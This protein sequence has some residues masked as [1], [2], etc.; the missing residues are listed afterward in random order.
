MN[1]KLILKG[2]KVI[3]LFLLFILQA[4]APNTLEKA[5]PDVNEVKLGEK[6]TIILPENHDEGILWKFNNDY[7]KSITDNLGAVWH[8]NEKGVY[9]RFQSLSAGTDTLMFTQFKTDAITKA[10]DTVKSV[11][12]I[13]KV[14]N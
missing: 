2:E 9:F 1:Y 5:A 8:G 14:T 12:Y 6:F 11:V 10:R 7:N 3:M 4:C 13:V